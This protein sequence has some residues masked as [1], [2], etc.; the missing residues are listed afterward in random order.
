[1]AVATYRGEKSVGEIAN[2]IYARLTPKQRE[3]AE[4]ALLKANPQLRNIKTLRKGSILRVPDLPDLRT[5][6]V[7]TLENPDAQ[8]AE[9]VSEALDSYS[10]RLAEQFKS[11]NEATKTQIALLKSAKLKRALADSP[12]LQELADAAGK[13]LDVRAKT[14]S[15]RQEALNKSIEQAQADLKKRAG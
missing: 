10:K 12:D 9:N 8:V 5:K 3:K 11:D 13:A 7:R 15:A 6:T 1:M 2:K 14:M 4:A